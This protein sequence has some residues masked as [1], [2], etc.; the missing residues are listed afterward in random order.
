MNFGRILFTSLDYSADFIQ[1]AVERPKNAIREIIQSVPIDLSFS[2]LDVHEQSLAVDQFEFYNPE[3]YD[4]NIELRNYLFRVLKPHQ[5]VTVE[6]SC[7]L[8]VQKLRENQKLPID[9]LS[10][11]V[12]RFYRAVN[13]RVANYGSIDD[14]FSSKHLL[15]QIESFLSAHIHEFMCPRLDDEA[16]DESFQDRVRSLNWVTQGFLETVLKTDYQD[17]NGNIDN[18]IVAIS[19][20]HTYVKIQ[21]KFQCITECAKSIENAI[22]ESTNSPA[23]ADDF[24]PVFIRILLQANP[25]MVVSNLRF[26]KHFALSS[27]LERGESNYYLYQFASCR[28]IHSR[29]QCRTIGHIRSIF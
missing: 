25:P 11:G 12:R 24:L 5:A 8:F 23:S 20:L 21:D 22:C 14:N 9:V 17:I 2:N 26:I 18:A 3:V 4:T 7:Y 10:D 27:K 13:E 16:L 15:C 1:K 28:S 19:K 6:N 29:N